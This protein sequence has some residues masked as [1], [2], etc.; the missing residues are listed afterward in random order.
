[1]IEA[2]SYLLW[3][4]LV[5]LPLVLTYKDTYKNIFPAEWYDEQPRDFLEQCPRHLAFPFGS[6]TGNTS[7][8]DRS[9]LHVDLLCV[10]D[11]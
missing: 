7:C 10:G 8:S 4:G 6:F 9:I 5:A 11:A 1:M 3:P 2:L